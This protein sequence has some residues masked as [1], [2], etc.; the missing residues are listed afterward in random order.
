[1]ADKT[2]ASFAVDYEHSLFSWS[3]EQNARDRQMTT[4]VTERKREAACSLR[5]R[6]FPRLVIYQER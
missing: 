5:S 1:M 3:V 4:R 2:K 6:A